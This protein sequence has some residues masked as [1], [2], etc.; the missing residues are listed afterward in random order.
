ME[1][2]FEHLH[3]EGVTQN[4]ILEA[5]GN[6]PE[7]PGMLSLLQY[8]RRPDC[9]V[10][11]LSDSNSVFISTWLEKYHLLDAIKQV[12]TNPA[13]FDASGQLHVNKFH[14]QNWCTLSSVN[15]C[16]GHILDTH[17]NSRKA[18]GVIFTGI[19]YVG[20]GHN[21]FCPS[22]RLSAGDH[23]FVRYGFSLEKMIKDKSPEHGEVKA[24][25]HM[26]R[27]G[28]DILHVIKSSI[29]KDGNTGSG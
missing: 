18:G 27:T 4:Q 1:K 29:I 14:N 11:I 13:H 9:E 24:S 3:H 26:W 22:L 17:I 16:K 8:L 6:I 12:Y 2:I 5:I 10:I 20:D 28:D 15:M 21:D 25:I 23:V 19:V 7:V